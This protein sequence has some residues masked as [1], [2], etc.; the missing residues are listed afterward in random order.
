MATE[1]T[2]RLAMP[3]GVPPAVKNRQESSKT[4]TTAR[5]KTCTMLR[6]RGTS[7]AIRAFRIR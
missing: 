3:L 4:S 2:M 1:T 5:L 7:A 6:G